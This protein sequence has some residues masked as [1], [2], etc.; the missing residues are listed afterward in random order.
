MHSGSS[1]GPLK[2]PGV[3]RTIRYVTPVP[4]TVQLLL[5]LRGNRDVW[6]TLTLPIS[7]NDF[8]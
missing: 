4:D 5:A 2:V 6:S 7:K 8:G 3:D 1:M